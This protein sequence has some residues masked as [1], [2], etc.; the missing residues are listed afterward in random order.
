MAQYI[1]RSGQ[2]LY[3]IALQLYGSVEG[4]FYLLVYNEWLSVNTE[5]RHGMIL[6]YGADMFINRDVVNWFIENGI[7]VKNGDHTYNFL[8]VEAALK[9]HF[10][11]EHP[12]II[13][14][15]DELSPD[16]QNLFWETQYTPRMII[17]QQGQLSALKLK[18]KTGTHLFI[19]WGD[20]SKLEI[21]EGEEYQETEHCYKSSGNHT[22]ILYGDFTCELL[23][24][25]ELNGIYYPL[26]TIY[27]NEFITNVK[28]ND[29]NKL[30]IPA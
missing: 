6:E 13:K 16:E 17:Q 26:G 21:L 10:E 19:D 2:N 30:I 14:T 8:D 11:E 20:Y 28:I 22:I 23:D 24:L 27:A 3:D 18:L 5:L 29:L 9:A 12:D 25:T 4:I 15:M 7:K 1:V